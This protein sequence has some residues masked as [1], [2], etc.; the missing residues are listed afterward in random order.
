MTEQKINALFDD[1]MQ[2]WKVHPESIYGDHIAVEAKKDKCSIVF[3]EDEYFKKDPFLD[4]FGFM[5]KN[6]FKHFEAT[7]HI[8][9]Q[10]K[11]FI[12]KAKD[13]LYKKLIEDEES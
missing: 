4:E 10:M 7:D 1:V 13:I 9:E 11:I 8:K 6:K 3:Y 12:E 5:Q 2:N